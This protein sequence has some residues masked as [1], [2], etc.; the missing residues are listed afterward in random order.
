MPR[1]RSDAEIARALRA[2][3]SPARWRHTLSVA[4]WA[5]ALAGRHGADAR[6][7]YTAGLVHDCA[8]EWS[9]A[10]LRAAVAGRRLRVP[11][12]AFILRHRQTGLFH[13]HVS[14]WE[15]RRAFG[16][17]DGAVLSAVARHTLGAGRMSRL[18]KVLYVADFSSPDRRYAAAAEVRRLARRDLDAALRAAV[19]HKMD[20]VLRTGRALHPQTVS[21]WNGLKSR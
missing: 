19:R 8:K 16:V 6:R 7:A 20:H 2:G 17:R 21:L 9:P 5:R 4:R 12:R 10:R 1:P 3:L 14:A 11:G 13:A 15:A 18:D